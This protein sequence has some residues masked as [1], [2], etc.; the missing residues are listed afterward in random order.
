[1]R[2]AASKLIGLAALVAHLTRQAFRNRRS[3]GLEERL[4][5]LPRSGLPIERRVE[6][7]WNHHQVPFI[8]A[9]TDHDLAV[10]LGIVHAHLRL[11]QLELMRRISQGRISELIGSCAFA[12][13]HLLYTLD[14]G[15]AVPGILAGMP[16]ATR[17]W[18]DA[19][20]RG[21][22]HCLT[23]VR[24]LPMEFDIFGMRPQ[25]WTPVDV[26]TLGRF[27]S[28]DV[29]WILAFQLLKFR[30]DAD[31]PLLWRELVSVDSLACGTSADPALPLG[32][33]LRSGSNS[34]VVA[35]SRTTSGAALLAGDPHLAITLPNAWLL[36][37][38]RSPSLHAAGLMIPGLPFIALGRNPWIAW[39]GTSLHAASSDLV[40]CPE[41]TPFTE[42]QVEVPVR[43]GRRRRLRLRNSR[44][45]PVI[46][47]APLLA[48]RNDTLALRWIGHRPS[49]E[50]TAMLAVNRARD[51]H[52]F[53]SALEGFAVPGQNMTYADVAGRIG[54]VTAVHL[55]RR[56]ADALDEMTSCPGAQES[57]EAIVT[58]ADLPFVTDPKE[59]FITSA[60]ERPQ[61]GAIPIGRHFSPPDRKHRLDRL[62]SS[63]PHVSAEIAARIQQDVHSA[64]MLNQCRQALEWLEVPAMRR[65]RPRERRLV[66]DLAAWDGC[67]QTTSRGALVFEVLCGHLARAIVPPRRM[68]AYRAAWGTRRLIWDRI[69][70]ADPRQRQRLARCALH[71]AARSIGPNETWGSRH[72]LRLGYPLALAPVVG[73]FWRYLDLPI[74]GSSDTLMKTAHALT[75]R[76]HATRYGSV[77]RQVCDLSDLDRNRFVLLG[78]QDGWPGSTTFLDQVP[79]W[80]RGEYITLPL[81]PE[82]ARATF[83]LRTK[84]SP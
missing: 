27:V 44:W 71:N 45:G 32:V 50:I 8:E 62:L 35:P 22:N 20:V 10:A 43:W 48:S 39:G 33:G 13:D 69:I 56:Q 9:E 12:V 25:P 15:R 41:D 51:W 53:T 54:R 83:P 1:M 29:N 78:G 70:S 77:A 80:L 60:N 26:L 42:R 11:G 49:D 46:T 30:G 14:F 5:M 36:A 75:A 40:L 6:I 84:L 4:A 82:T 47:D 73:R 37:A 38:I 66:D 79:V 23:H 57:W 17:S 31:W 55:P 61:D 16:A 59:G 74:A 64:S 68:A 24:P 76:R 67:Y 65:L 2:S 19:F 72:R 58:S 34:F 21:L 52:A 7:F 18:L 81:S 3:Y 28:A 63:T